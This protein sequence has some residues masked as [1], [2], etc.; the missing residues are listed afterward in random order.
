MKK[1][2][3]FYGERDSEILIHTNKEEAIED[4]LDVLDDLISPMPKEIEICAFKRVNVKDKLTNLSGE[5]L[6]ILLEKLDEEY[7]D[8]E[9]TE[10]RPSKKMT[11]ASLVFVSSILEDYIPWRCEIFEKEKINCKEWITKNNPEWLGDI[12]FEEDLQA[13]EVGKGLKEYL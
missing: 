9:G 1:D 7:G 6:S 8:L 2:D 4:V 10:T 3:I 12:I 11:D 5:I 13:N